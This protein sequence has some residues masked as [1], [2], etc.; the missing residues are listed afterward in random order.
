M[1]QRIG[2]RAARHRVALTQPSPLLPVA[3]PPIT[4]NPDTVALYI[5]YIKARL[6]PVDD[7]LQGCCGVKFVP[8]VQQGKAVGGTDLLPLLQVQVD[9]GCAFRGHGLQSHADEEHTEESFHDGG[10]IMY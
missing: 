4:V 1:L 7:A 10:G 6:F 9:D 5:I 3:V 2:H 8:K